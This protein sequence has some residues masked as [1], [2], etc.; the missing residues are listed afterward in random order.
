[1]KN[2]DGFHVLVM[3]LLRNAHHGSNHIYRPVNALLA[4][5]NVAQ[6][7]VVENEIHAGRHRLGSDSG[8]PK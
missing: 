3:Y 4:A 5:L 6:S 7:A 1:M 2:G 8:P